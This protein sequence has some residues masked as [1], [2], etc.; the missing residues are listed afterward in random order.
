M[1]TG[2]IEKN[3]NAQSVRFNG[4]FINLSELHRLT[5]VDL[6]YL[7]KIMSGKRQP[8]LKVSRLI[9]LELGIGLEEFLKAIDNRKADFDRMS[10]PQ[11]AA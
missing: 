3:P 10:A 5:G 8:S 2:C 1:S 6:G 7:S 9:A 11:R 4:N